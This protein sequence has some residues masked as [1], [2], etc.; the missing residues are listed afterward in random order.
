ML[1]YQLLT[2]Y[3]PFNGNSHE[4]MYQVLNE[5]PMPPSA[6]HRA[7]GPYFDSVV[8]KAIA[9]EPEQRFDSA[10]SF[11]EALL[12]AYRASRQP[13][14][15]TAEDDMTVLALQVPPERLQ[16]VLPT[17]PRSLP[18]ASQLS[19]SYVADTAWKQEVLPELESLLSTQIGPVARL[20]VKKSLLQADN[21]EHLCDDLLQHIP[22]DKGRTLFLQGVQQIRKKY[23]TSIS[24][25]NS[26]MNSGARSSNPGATRSGASQFVSAGSSHAGQGSGA[27]SRS[28]ILRTGLNATTLGPPLTPEMQ[29]QAEQ[30][31][32]AYIGPIAKIVCKRAAGKTANAHEF[33]RLLA[34]NLASEAERNKFLRECGLG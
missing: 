22:N 31:L 10:R 32:T 26:G 25:I 15:Q 24:G 29:A 27:A 7:L 9:K 6:R 18:D 1:L 13:G 21:L 4:I 23:S 16:E 33:Y 19:T 17:P 34:D 8:A 5:H 3:R 28:G 14:M 20:F 11:M 30:K 2:G 12:Q